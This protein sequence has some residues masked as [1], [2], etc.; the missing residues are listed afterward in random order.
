MVP[1]A[2][3][4]YFSSAAT[5]AG[6]LI[7]LLFVAISVRSDT[8][9]GQK[10]MAGGE[11][12]AI[13]AFTGLVNAFFVSMLALIPAAD[14]GIGAVIGAVISIVSLVRL[15]RRITVRRRTFSFAL[16]LIAY[17][18]QLIIGMILI[19][20]PHDSVQVQNLAYIIFASMAVALQRAWSLMRGRHIVP[21]S[22]QAD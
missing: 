11:A 2:Y 22:E 16:T 15:N 9:F 19:S 3:D 10:S 14:I 21:D 12:L 5:A 20:R 1:H 6:A 18:A 7:G 4:G 13:T 17:A 8:I